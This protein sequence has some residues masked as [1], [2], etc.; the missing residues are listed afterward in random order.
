MTQRQFTNYPTD[1]EFIGETTMVPKP[2]NITRIYYTNVN[3]ISPLH[4][5]EQFKQILDNITNLQ[6]DIIAFAE[7][8]LAVDQ[9]KTR[10]DLTSTIKKHLPNSRTISSTSEIQFP[11]AYKPG[12]CLTIAT[13]SIQSRINLHGSDRFGRWTY[14][15]L[16]T[17]AQGMIVIITVYKPCK[18]NATSGPL[19][20]YRQQWTMLRQSDIDHPDP[21]KQFDDDFLKFIRQLQL[22]SHRII[23]IGDFNETRN[24]SKLFQSL[25]SLGLQDMVFSRHENIP[26]FRSCSRGNNVIDY[27]LCSSSL[28]PYIQ[29]SA[30]EPFMFT[31]TS[32]HR[33]IVIDFDTRNLLGRPEKIQ[34]PDHRGIN[35]NNP[36]LIE[37][38]INQLQ[39]LWKKY[40]IDQRIKAAESNSHSTPDLQ[41]L[42]NEID[43]D[44]TRAMLQAERRVKKAEKPPWSPAL[45]QA[46]LSVKYYKLLRQQHLHKTDLSTAIQHT[47]QQ[48][49]LQPQ[50]PTS[51]QEYQ[52]LLRKAQKTLKSIRRTAQEHRTRHLEILLQRYALLD[53]KKMQ[54]TVKRIIQAEATKRCYRKLRWITKPNKPGV[55]FVERTNSDGSTETLYDRSSV[56]SA[57][58]QRNQ[59][60]FNQCAGTPFTVG[61][62]RQIEWA[63]DTPLA[64]QILNGTIK[65]NTI[66]DD[67]RIQQILQTCTQIGDVISDHISVHDLQQLFKKWRETTT[68]SPSGRHL[69]IYKAI[70][71]ESQKDDATI[72]NNI[73]TMINLL[74]QNGIGLDRWRNVTNMMIHKL[75]GSY[76]INKLRV[77]HLFEADYNGLIGIL[78]N[79]RVLYQAEQQRI[80]NNNQW[81]GRPHRQ[82][83]D[84]LM[85]KEFTYNL[86]AST[87]TTLATFDND[88]TGC[89]D[90]VPC[91]VAMLSSRRFGA[92]TNMCR[93]QANTLS[94]IRHSLRTAFGIS[95]ASYTSHK[96]WEIHGQGQG[97]RAGPPTWVFVSALL[98]DCMDKLANGL[99]FTCPK[100]QLHHH[101][102]NDAFVDDV[103]GY[104]NRFIEELHG[105]RVLQ[106]VLKQMQ[107]DAT[108]WSELLHISGGKL[109]LHKCLYYIMT[110]VW[111]RNDATTLPATNIEP[112]ILLNQTPIKHYNCTDAHRTLGQYKA[113]DGNTSSQLDFMKQKSTN[114][115]H[116]IHEANLTKQEAQAAYDMMWFPS[117]SYGLGTTNLSYR[118]LNKIQKPIINHILPKLGYNRHLPRAVV[119]GSSKFGGLNLKHLYID[120]GT[121][122]VT[123]FIKYYRNGGSIGDLLKISLQWLRLIAG[124]S[125]CPLAQPQPNYHHIDDRWYTTTIRFLYECKASIQTNDTIRIFCRHHDSCLM[126]DFL[127]CDPPPRDLKVLNQ[128]RLFLRVSTLSDICS[129]DGRTITRQCWEGLHPV[130]STLLW[131]K[132]D[133]PA[134]SSWSTWRK[135]ITR[136]YLQD[137]SNTRKKRSNLQLDTELG[138]WL[139]DHPQHQ[140]RQYY[141]NPIS[142]TLY[143]HNDSRIQVFAPY[144][145]TRTQLT[146]QPT[147]RVFQRPPAT[148]PVECTV[149]PS[150]PTH[151]IV[152]KH[153]L[154]QIPRRTPN[155]ITSFNDYIH[156]LE[157]WEEYLLQHHHIPIRDAITIVSTHN[158][159]IASDGSVGDHKGSFGWV[160]STPDAQILATGS[161]RAFGYKVSS[162]RSESYGFLAPLRFLYHLQCYYQFP[163][164]NRT[165]TWFCDSESLLKRIQ[166]NKHDTHNPNRF[167]LADNDLEY[168]IATSIPLV[169]YKLQQ[170][171]VRSH[172]YDNI[173]LHLLPL[174]HR[175]NRMADALAAD[176]HKWNPHS[177]QHV[178]LISLA[179]C[180][181]NTPL[182]TITR[183]YTRTL[184][185]AF[186]EQATRKHLC[187]RLDIEPTTFNAIA[188]SEFHRAFQTLT[189][190]QKRITRKWLFGYLPTQRRLA[191]Y[192]LSNSDRCPVC[193]QHTETDAHF[194]TCGGSESWKDN[195]FDPLLR[196]FHKHH[197]HHTFESEIISQMRQCLNQQ[198]PSPSVQSTVGWKAMFTGILHHEWI[199]QYNSS[200]TSSP[201]TNGSFVITKI[202]R[203]ILSAVVTRWKARCLALHQNNNTNTETRLRLQHQ[204]RAMYACRAQMLPQDTIILD[205]PL[206]PFLQQSTLTLRL[207]VSQYKPIIKQSIQRQKEQLKRQHRDISEYFI[208]N[209]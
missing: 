119:F 55:T 193:K 194:L 33:G 167:K 73:T 201:S 19:T 159:I 51:P 174:P 138:P 70:F 143:Q 157:A 94:H 8:N 115:L 188:W 202:I 177:T 127:L 65:P 189:Q 96:D 84:A 140:I 121:K 85:L 168:A 147:G 191:R 155:N 10:Y 86:A 192:Q 13:S 106:D 111:K 43:C 171:H 81:G 97:S 95:P 44:I 108:L 105:N 54:K 74:V 114:W 12:G 118:E 61:R 30:Y 116:A 29:A 175:L 196:L 47:L 122:H 203:I 66:S 57:I 185:A 79:R 129:S 117:L 26:P 148:I 170:K 173:P 109:A 186:T 179:G 21:R 90:R 166:S 184:Q 208:R 34:S 76:N 102:T 5:Y 187:N 139:P 23:I 50:T 7:H 69:G 80:L 2:K 36:I 123:Q 200:S 128:C 35:A 9:S 60:H 41:Q 98:L 11:T 71:V 120:Q 112:K 38:F 160:I 195:L 104:T 113:P 132:Q 56:E 22:Q 169:T 149:S 207:F 101:R 92:T 151:R 91:S 64:E 45:K 48:M 153:N 209:R 154:P 131:P 126:E 165:V 18:N 181:M 130:H 124:F 162:F 178:P 145:N 37:K 62:L 24:R 152:H 42:L 32:D 206:T 158:I 204:I 28:C 16:V 183:S 58:L 75:D 100:Q 83:K 161:G 4:Q 137:E 198:L 20:V 134:S 141:I 199:T 68:T 89:F 39:T 49:E 6:T 150:N 1:N 14:M 15:G 59:R 205:T 103:T 40:N 190:S 163:L 144:R 46:S 197:T 135:Y 72:R 107:E 82:A 164:I 67:L 180:Q 52:T 31:T 17:K 93:M 78:F 125:F 110:W 133:K 176:V 53:E 87:K 88:A 182:G 63:A 156:N 77:I 146:Y 172:Q 136:C 27:A 25:S 142:L 3:G 99:Y